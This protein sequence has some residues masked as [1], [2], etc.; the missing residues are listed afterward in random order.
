MLSGA[1][2]RAED[3]RL[4]AILNWK[5]PGAIEP[6]TNEALYSD[7]RYLKADL[8]PNYSIGYLVLGLRYLDE[9]R[10]ESGPMLE[11]ETTN[12]SDQ[13]L[14][15]ALADEDLRRWFLRLWTAAG[16]VDFLGH[17]RNSVGHQQRDFE[18]L[19]RLLPTQL[20][21]TAAE[22]FRELVGMTV[23]LI[24]DPKSSF[25]DA[26]DRTKVQDALGRLKYELEEVTNIG[27]AAPA[28]SL[29][30]ASDCR[31]AAAVGRFFAHIEFDPRISPETYGSDSRFARLNVSG[32][33]GDP[34]AAVL[35]SWIAFCRA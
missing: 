10:R 16:D 29:F 3:R 34:L 28:F 7:V 20:N 9:L 27:M 13:D 24:P 30:C 31:S 15:R 12:L 33:A 4:E 19:G 17:V 5:R 2:S 1:D 25:L 32:Y 26:G 22:Q 11:D 21:A 8:P 6:Y 18:S 14:Q 35:L 23:S